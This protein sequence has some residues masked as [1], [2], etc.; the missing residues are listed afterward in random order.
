MLDDCSTSRWIRHSW[1]SGDRAAEAS[2]RLDGVEEHRPGY[3]RV[4]SEIDESG[5]REPSA[6]ELVTRLSE[7]ISRL[8]RDELQLALTELK[9]K[10]KRAGIGGGLIA[11]AGTVALLGLGA[12]MVAAIVALARS[13]P[14][15]AAALIVGGA[16]L[17]L[18]GLLALLGIDQLKSAIP[19]IPEQAI[20]SM[21]RSAPG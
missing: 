10:A 9:H 2:I 3:L 19:P 4:M 6:A 21:K 20:A 8:V 5:H 1:A 12:L 14:L 16:A 7:Q 15:W 17:L 11:A 13:L 18:A